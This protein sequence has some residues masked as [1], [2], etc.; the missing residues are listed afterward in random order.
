MSKVI[1]GTIWE[2][3][4]CGKNNSTCT[5]MCW[6]CGTYQSLN[7]TIRRTWTCKYCGC[8]TK[9]WGGLCNDRG[10]DDHDRLEGIESRLACL[11]NGSDKPLVDYGVTLRG[12]YSSNTETRDAIHK[13][14][15][16][17]SKSYHSFTQNTIID[18]SGYCTMNVVFKFKDKQ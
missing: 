5:D 17:N 3:D 7:K 13:M 11:E 12:G 16:Q 9:S 10:Y 14:L 18:P 1:D 15:K 6:N 4:V 2:C 8:E